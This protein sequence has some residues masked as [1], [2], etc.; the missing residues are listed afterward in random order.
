VAAA[1]IAKKWLAEHHGVQVRGYLSQIGSVTP[2]AFDPDSIDWT[3]VESNPFFWPDATQV[4]ELDSFM[5]ALRKSGDSV[6]ARVDVVAEGLPPGWGEPIY[7]KLDGAAS[8][9]ASARARRCGCPRRSSRLPAC[10]CRR[11]AWIPT[12]MRSK[13]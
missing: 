9:A 5:D 8:S 3:V 6:G 11:T 2:R 13:W 10:G 7:G 1:V 12:A 4:D